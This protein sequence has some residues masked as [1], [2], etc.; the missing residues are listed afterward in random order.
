[1]DEPK[2]AVDLTGVR[3]CLISGNSVLRER[4]CRLPCGKAMPFRLALFLLR[5]CASEAQPPEVFGTT[6]RHSLSARKAA[7]PRFDKDN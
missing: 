3:S 7:Q 1:M 2:N 5:G 4:L 6:E